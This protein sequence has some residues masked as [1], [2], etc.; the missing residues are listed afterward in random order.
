MLI[1]IPGY[2]TMDLKYLILDFNGTLALDGIFIPGIKEKLNLLSE[3]FEVFV[4]T[5]DTFG[6][7]KDQCKDLKV[8]VKVFTG[9]DVSKE[10]LKFVESLGYESCVTI[11]NGRNDYYM[12]RSAILSI[13][14]IGD[15]GMYSGLAE[16]ADILIPSMSLGL[17]LLLEPR[18][19][20]ASLRG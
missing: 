20:I 2:L 8:K 3:K 7:V 9:E 6:S 16:A 18:R 14:V 19:L 13:A 17:D 15:E 5:A 12:L 11:G 10:K 4:L 1:D